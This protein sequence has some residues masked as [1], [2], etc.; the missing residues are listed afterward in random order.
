MIMNFLMFLKIEKT[1]I[2]NEL[3][4]LIGF[5]FILQINSGRACFNVI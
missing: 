5:T 2:H 4:V 1:L 3:T